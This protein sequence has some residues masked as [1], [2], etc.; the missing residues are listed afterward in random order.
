MPELK[1]GQMRVSVTA[2]EEEIKLLGEIIMLFLALPNATAKRRVLDYVT[3]F[4]KQSR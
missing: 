1:D 2:N 3:D 4:V